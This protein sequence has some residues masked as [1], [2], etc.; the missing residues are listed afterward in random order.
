MTRRT[1]VFTHN[2]SLATTVDRDCNCSTKSDSLST[3]MIL[4][5]ISALRFAAAELVP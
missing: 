2:R 3:R 1:V 5:A 4:W